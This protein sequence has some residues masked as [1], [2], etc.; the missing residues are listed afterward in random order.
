M[1][2][3]MHPQAKRL[4]DAHVEYV[5]S[6][7]Q[8]PA[9]T[10]LLARE[11]DELFADASRITL[12]EAVTPAMIKATVLS[13]AVEIELSGAIPEL[14]GDIARALYAH[15]VHGNTTLNDLLPDGLFEEFLDKGLEMRELHEWIVHEAIANP[16]YSAL[17]TD[18]VVEGIRGYLHHGGARVRSLPGLRQASALG[19]GLLR[20][21]LPAIEE[22]LEESL[23]TYL[24]KSL[25]DLL[26]GSEEF[27]LGLFDQEQVRSLAL[28]A[29]D[30]VKDKRIA[31]FQEG[32]S[33][34]DIE[35]FFVIG[36][37]AWR[38]V[39]GTPLYSA[40][41]EAGIDAFFDKYGSTPLRELI[42]EMGVSREIALREATRFAP[43][44]LGALHQK[45]LLEPLVRRHLAGFY[46]SAAVAAIV[47]DEA[48]AARPAKPRATSKAA[49]K[50]D[51]EAAPKVTGAKAVRKPLKPAAPAKS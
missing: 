38:H 23:R 26:Q 48:P 12:D 50:T 3:R 42:D 28:E 35:E 24:Q 22:T 32:V 30:I 27:L 10:A 4:L 46:A 43:H 47:G 51:P 9:L 18:I 25:R 11:V 17:A 2:S 34:L 16:V 44:V 8:G 1:A 29:W 31:D 33:S 20:N 49:P 14:V 13:Y 45:H 5:M 41:I 40:M 21:A 19:S 6:Q 7:L 15:P 36:Y 39:R 37:E